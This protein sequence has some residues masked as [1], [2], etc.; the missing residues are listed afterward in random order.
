MMKRMKI[1]TEEIYYGG[2][3][4]EYDEAEYDAY[5][6]QEEEDYY[7]G[8]RK[9]IAETDFDSDL[10]ADFDAMPTP[11]SEEL[12]G[13]AKMRSVSASSTTSSRYKLKSAKKSSKKT[14]KK[15]SKKKSR[16]SLKR[17]LPPALRAFQKLVKHIAEATGK[18]GKPA[19]QLAKKVKN[20]LLAN[21]PHLEKDKLKL[22]EE[23][24]K[25]FDKNKKLYM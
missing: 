17:E 25:Y 9:S 19:M 13:G 18:A 5:M 12:Y 3:M 14:P 11:S 7:G 16:K 21:E 24:I 22:A 10:K 23:A 8:A 4:D 1:M 20:D 6:E 15:T 2:A